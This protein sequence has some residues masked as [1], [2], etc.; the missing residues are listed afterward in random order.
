MQL[1]NAASKMH[2]LTFLAIG[3]FGVILTY[4]EVEKSH[5]KLES[6]VYSTK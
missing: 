2:S 5:S 4:S 1:L 6:V 3:V